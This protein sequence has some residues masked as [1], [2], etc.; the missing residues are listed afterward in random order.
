MKKLSLSALFAL[1]MITSAFAAKELT[2]GSNG[3]GP[4]SKVVAPHFKGVENFVKAFPQATGVAYEVKGQFTEVSFTWNDLNL[5]AFYDME[6]NPIGTSRA[7][8]VKALPLS[9]MLDIKREYAGYVITDAIEFDNADT[10][11]S[12]YITV[13]GPEKAYVLHLD[14]DG[15]IS[16]FKKMKY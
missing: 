7:V 4:H 2:P 9:Y 3:V 16:V 6:G 11:L 8:D 15:T 13:V 14:T 12:Y 5:L 1:V 10:G